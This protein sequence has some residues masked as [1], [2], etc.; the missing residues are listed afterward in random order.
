MAWC[1]SIFLFTVL[2]EEDIRFF[3]EEATALDPCFKNKMDNNTAVWE[4]IKG[5]ILANS[6][7]VKCDIYTNTVSLSP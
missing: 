1:D 3:L 4:R 7:Q 5:N 2:K 6:E